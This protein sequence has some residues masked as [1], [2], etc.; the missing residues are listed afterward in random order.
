MLLIPSSN[1]WQQLLLLLSELAWS[2]MY[3]NM[4]QSKIQKEV[5]ILVG[6]LQLKTIVGA[7]QIKQ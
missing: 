1:L 7:M 5:N 3:L 4:A 6:K 2:L